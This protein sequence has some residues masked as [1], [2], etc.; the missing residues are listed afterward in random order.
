LEWFLS[1]NRFPLSHSKYRL[2]RLRSGVLTVHSSAYNEKLHPGLGPSAEA[3]QLHIGQAT[4]LSR[5]QSYAGEFVVWDVGLGAA[6]NALT[7]LR[8]T[9]DLPS[10]LRLVSFDDTVEPLSFALLNA[11]KLEYLRA[12]ES[13]VKTLIERRRVEFR[14]G[15]HSVNWE[16][17]VEDFP[18]L[19]AQNRAASVPKPHAILFDPFSPAKNPGMWTLTLFENL[20][21]LLDP[22]RLCAMTTYSRSTMIRVS[23]LLAGFFVGRGRPTGM[24]EETTVAANTPDLLDELLDANW[25]QR[26]RT[27]TSA[28]PLTEAA[29]RQSLLSA[30]TWRRLQQHT[31]FA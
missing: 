23:L 28:E 22:S 18:S 8:L 27:S 9:R 20:F 14:D 7:L 19:I 24:K 4:I 25:L 15:A 3:E 16:I 31:Q 26:A 30:D 6:A 2:V 21:R 11:D 17:H 29:Y 1:R 13:P 5:L 10:P 12:Y